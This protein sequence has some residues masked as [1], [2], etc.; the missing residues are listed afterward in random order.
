VADV[1]VVS[2]LWTGKER[3][4]ELIAMLPFESSRAC[5]AYS[6]VVAVELAEFSLLLP[7]LLLLLLDAQTRA[8]L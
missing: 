6:S 3:S 5:K 8:H 1:E 4:K 2:D 7:P